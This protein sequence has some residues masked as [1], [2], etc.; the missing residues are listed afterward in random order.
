MPKYIII[1][2]QNTQSLDTADVLVLE[3]ICQYPPKTISDFVRGKA[4]YTEGLQG[5]SLYYDI[6]KGD[7]NFRFYLHRQGQ[8]DIEMQA[9][10]LRLSNGSLSQDDIKKHG[11]IK[12]LFDGNYHSSKTVDFLIVGFNEDNRKIF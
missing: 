9:P 4:K 5:T 11:I 8:Q 3:V 1:A 2:H 12:I 10:T 6:N 7:A